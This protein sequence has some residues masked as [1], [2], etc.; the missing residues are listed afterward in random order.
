[1]KT[2]SKII[3]GLRYK[4]EAQKDG[5]GK[6]YYH[7]HVEDQLLLM[8]PDQFQRWKIKRSK[9]PFWVKRVEFELSE[10]IINC[11]K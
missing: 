3:D 10:A 8:K 7:V 4:F 2:F 5:Y 11:N 1:M 6:W 9:I